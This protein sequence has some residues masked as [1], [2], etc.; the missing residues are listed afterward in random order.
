MGIKQEKRGTGRTHNMI[1]EALQ[2]GAMSNQ[3]ASIVV[4]RDSRCI[5]DALGAIVPR[6]FGPHDH[7]WRIIAH[8][9]CVE[10]AGKV[11]LYF[12]RMNE[13]C[14]KFGND[15]NNPHTWKVPGHQIF[16]D[17]LIF[18]DYYG[19]ILQA[20]TRYDNPHHKVNFHE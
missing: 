13:V 6:C 20:W 2:I 12:K 4:M 18:E 16:I 8:T 19:A 9:E 7:Y 15:P 5:Q 11:V 10:V 3:K 17:H 14:D 1:M